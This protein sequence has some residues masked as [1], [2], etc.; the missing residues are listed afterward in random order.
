MS[1]KALD[2]GKLQPLETDDRQEISGTG[3]WKADHRCSYDAD[4]SFP[5]RRGK[6]GVAVLR[7]GKH[8]RQSHY[9]SI[10]AF[11]D[12]IMNFI[13]KNMVNK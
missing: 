2:K 8:P 5:V 10:D 1:T 4:T 11:I 12:G 7:T 13:K 6:E 9:G 3:A